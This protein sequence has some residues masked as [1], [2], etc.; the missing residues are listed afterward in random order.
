[1]TKKVQTVGK[2]KSL[3]LI[4]TKPNWAREVRE[5]YPRA[6]YTGE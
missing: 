1:M 6:I 3:F 4:K 2:S 5:I